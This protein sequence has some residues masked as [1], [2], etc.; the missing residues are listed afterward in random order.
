MRAASSFSGILP[1]Q[2]GSSIFASV[3][4]GVTV[5]VVT[6]APALVSALPHSAVPMHLSFSCSS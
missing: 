3:A 4:V 1:A 5:V 2:R 6:D